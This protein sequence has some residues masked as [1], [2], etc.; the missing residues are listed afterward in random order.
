[1]YLGMKG[2]K[3]V[4]EARKGEE[5]IR[6][7]TDE[8]PDVVILDIQLADDIDGIA[9]LR[10]TKTRWPPVI[11]GLKFVEKRRSLRNLRFLRKGRV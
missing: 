11:I 8:K 6:K 9:V 3:D 2:F 1:M 10:Q 7:I 5:A 4:L